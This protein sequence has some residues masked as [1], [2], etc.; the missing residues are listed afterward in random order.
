MTGARRKGTRARGAPSG[1]PSGGASPWRLAVTRLA[2]PFVALALVAFLVVLVRTAWLSDDAFITF[3]VSDNLVHGFGPTW[4]AGER[5][6]VFTHPLWFLLF[7]VCYLITRE[8]YFTGIV[9]S[10]AVSLATALFV[11][12]RLTPSPWTAGCAV[13][14][15]SFSRAFVDYSTSGLENPLS[16]LLLAIFLHEWLQHPRGRRALTR[17]AIV[18]GLGALNRMDLAL[19]FGPLLG[20]ALWRARGPHRLRVGLLALAPLATWEAFSLLYYGSLF[21][22]VAYAKLSHDVATLELVARGL[23]YLEAS[24][25]GDPL[26]LVL[27]V[28][29]LASTALSAHRP[30]LPIA[31]VGLLHLGYVVVI[32]GD[33]MGGRFLTVPLLAAVVVLFQR[34]PG[35]P[36]R[37]LAAAA[38]L[39]ALGMVS[40]Y[41]TLLSG[42]A[43]GDDRGQGQLVSNRQGVVSEFW[44]HLGD[45]VDRWGV[46]DERGYYYHYTG[47][48]RAAGSAQMPTL[49]FAGWGK[50]LRT[51]GRQT[52]VGNNI[53]C[54]GYFAGPE[55]TIIDENG[56]TDSYLSR[57]PPKVSHS[58][59]VGHFARALP[60]GY[61]RSLELG[62]NEI[63]DPKLRACFERT[64]LVARG[65]LL[66]PAR[67]AAI[68]QLVW[69][70]CADLI[71]V[72]AARFPVDRDVPLDALQAIK[73]AGT[74]ANAPG[75][76]T[77]G[78]NGGVRI[79]LGRTAH[80]R[81][82]E[83]SL[84]DDDIYFVVL[85]ASAGAELVL[86]VPDLWSDSPLY[87]PPRPRPR[88]T[89]L[90]TYELSVPEGFA[91]A[92]YDEIRI[93]DLTGGGVRSLG[94]LSL[95]DE[96]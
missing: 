82:L 95:R 75:N 93:L 28:A 50:L 26:T 37:G 78:K 63:V 11:A 39:A 33:F 6:Q 35:T 46:A 55:V 21:P 80:A 30:A 57:L 58:W 61:E 38:G 68:A 3:R 79:A 70:G 71:D 91:R 83:L 77:F 29:A 92:G 53:G 5:T 7:S 34:E 88:S 86:R 14:A 43:Y 85:L 10:L 59:R 94:H 9:L 32:G 18:A 81:T 64:S 56:L 74:P 42:S 54:L 96:P 69:H 24:V 4:N 44:R 47:L 40:P 87:L 19:V 12:V 23:R 76:V 60:D 8:P 89:G 17:L 52:I 25:T 20:I 22:N 36:G 62:S 51:Q 66:D 73:P 67:L 41:P 90:A 65:E 13:L 1:K 48:L 72:R 2:H 45:F 16:H 49:W 31:A 15:L 84:D 27:I